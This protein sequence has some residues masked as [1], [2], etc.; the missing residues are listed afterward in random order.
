MEITEEQ[1]G[2]ITKAFSARSIL[3]EISN[4]FINNEVL[5]KE[6]FFK[7]ASKGNKLTKK[8]FFSEN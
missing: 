8:R 6:E 4:H 3:I 2:E 7:L 5:T 1:K